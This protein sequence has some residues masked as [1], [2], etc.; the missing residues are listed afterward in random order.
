MGLSLCVYPIAQV[1]IRE[2]LIIA[3][4]GTTAIRRASHDLYVWDFGVDPSA[5]AN[6]DAWKPNPSASQPPSH[7]ATELQKPR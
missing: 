6:R 4:D 5:P 7:Q 2:G 1:R 3:S